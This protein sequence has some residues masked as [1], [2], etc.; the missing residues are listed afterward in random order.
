MATNELFAPYSGGFMTFS[1]GK[2]SKTVAGGSTRRST[3]IAVTA[4]AQSISS[5]KS[6]KSR[7]RFSDEPQQ[8]ALYQ[9][10]HILFL[11]DVKDALVS[12]SDCIRKEFAEFFLE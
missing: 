3:R 12:K 8:A 11:L 2:P 6:S 5:K 7:N 9:R 1:L 10:G 4:I